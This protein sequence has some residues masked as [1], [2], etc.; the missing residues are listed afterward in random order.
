MLANLGAKIARRLLKNGTLSLEESVRCSE[1]LLAVMGALPFKDII[2]HNE[3]GRI[4]VNGKEIDIDQAKR[5]RANATAALENQALTLIREQAAYT[6]VTVG[7][8]KAESPN[9]MFFA[10]AALWWGQQEHTLL[11]LLAGRELPPSED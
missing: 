3:F 10:R 7:V 4:T 9:Q 8:H 2:T 6:A 11:E 5:L 1:A